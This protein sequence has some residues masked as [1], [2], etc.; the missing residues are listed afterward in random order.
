MD[1]VDA[2]VWLV[3]DRCFILQ[4]GDEK[5]AGVAAGAEVLDGWKELG[6]GIQRDRTLPS[7]ELRQ[8]WTWHPSRECEGSL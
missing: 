1:G 7:A 5:C 8:I 2:D 6:E 3:G 4:I